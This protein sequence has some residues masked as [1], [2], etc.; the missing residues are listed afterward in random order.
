MLR[1][2]QPCAVCQ[3]DVSI[4]TFDYRVSATFKPNCS[5][6][7]TNNRPTPYSTMTKASTLTQPTTAPAG[8]L[9][10]ATH[11]LCPRPTEYEDAEKSDVNRRR[12][13][14]LL[15]HD[16]TRSALRMTSMSERLQAPKSHLLTVNLVRHL[17]VRC[18]GDQDT[19]S[20]MNVAA[21][22]STSAKVLVSS[23]QV[24]SMTVEDCQYV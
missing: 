15:R 19:N 22:K 10:E 13:R 11:R 3:A 7:A 17:H 6:G 21:C 16:P 23:R 5:F 1:L 18:D 8:T 24:L 12:H 14:R 20:I 2:R 9:T 4:S